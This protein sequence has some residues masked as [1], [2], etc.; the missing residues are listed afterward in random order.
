MATPSKGRV[1]IL[2]LAILEC[3]IMDGCMDSEHTQALLK[4]SLIESFLGFRG[5]ERSALAEKSKIFQGKILL[6]LNITFGIRISV[7]RPLKTF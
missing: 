3:G 7:D 1:G 2:P 4:A 6:I 5:M